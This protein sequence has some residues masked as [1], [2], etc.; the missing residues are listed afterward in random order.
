MCQSL[1]SSDDYLVKV[2]VYT[3][4]K[5][6]LKEDVYYSGPIRKLTSA[7]KEA[8][9]QKE[10]FFKKTNVSD[11]KSEIL[12]IHYEPDGIYQTSLLNE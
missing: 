7:R 6:Y 12:I 4:E 11:V 3:V 2:Y 10:K 9:I 8:S 1:T 5:D